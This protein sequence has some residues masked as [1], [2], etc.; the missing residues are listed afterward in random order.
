MNRVEHRHR[1]HPRAVEF[2]CYVGNG[3]ISSAHVNAAERQRLLGTY[4][5]G[6]AILRIFCKCR[7][8]QIAVT[9][10]R[11]AAHLLRSCPNLHYAA[12]LPVLCPVSSLEALE[13]ACDHHRDIRGAAELD[14]HELDVS[15]GDDVANWIRA[16]AGNWV[17]RSAKTRHF[18]VFAIHVVERHF[19]AK[20]RRY[21]NCHRHRLRG[22]HRK[23]HGLGVAVEI[24]VEAN[25]AG[26][27][28][29]G[30][31]LIC[32]RIPDHRLV[33]GTNQFIERLGRI[34]PKRLGVGRKVEDR[35]AGRRGERREPRVRDEHGVGRLGRTA[36]GGEGAG[37]RSAYE[38]HE[39]GVFAAGAR[40]NIEVGERRERNDVAVDLAVVFHAVKQIVERL[41]RIF[42]YAHYIAEGIRAERDQRHAVKAGIARHVRAQAVDVE[43]VRDVHRAV[44]V[45]ACVVRERPPARGARQ[46]REPTHVVDD[47]WRQIREGLQ[48]ER[49]NRRVRAAH[50]AKG[51]EDAPQPVVA[52][53]ERIGS[54][55]RVAEHDAWKR[56]VV[57]AVEPLR[58]VGLA[59]VHLAPVW[60][61]VVVALQL[62]YG[63]GE[64]GANEIARRDV[65]PE[66]ARRRAA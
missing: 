47:R 29:V 2:Q 57:D 64:G 62:L 25:Q 41:G 5:R 8:I 1:W 35:L 14:S 24:V 19:D 16:A 23:R 12:H 31:E 30:V 54:R 20:G 53:M 43:E 51:H 10:L 38:V 32:L 56:I 6:D 39:R 13:R 55:R 27:E 45:A 18:V 34:L 65:A 63:L 9:V 66:V 3:L 26:A 40:Q 50:C 46:A 7:W 37:L 52:V 11:T 44:S 33:E 17:S 61:A 42:F 4:K 15:L 48:G 59:V 28:V 58:H 60:I 21:S 22:R 49:R 36:L